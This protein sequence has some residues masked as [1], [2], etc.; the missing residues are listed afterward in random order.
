MSEQKS[1][2]EKDIDSLSKQLNDITDSQTTTQLINSFSTGLQSILH[3][4]FGEGSHEFYMFKCR[5]QPPDHI[6]QA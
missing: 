6:Q 2:F 4:Q 3:S 5:M 1:V